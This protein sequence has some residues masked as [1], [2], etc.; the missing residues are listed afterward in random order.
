MTKAK[1]VLRMA[2]I[3]SQMY[4]NGNLTLNAKRGIGEHF[5][6]LMYTKNAVTE[7]VIQN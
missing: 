2:S 7:T 1:T 6:V 5:Y 4:R 3:Y